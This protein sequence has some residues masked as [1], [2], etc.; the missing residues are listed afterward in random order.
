MKTTLL[1]SLV[2]QMGR[3]TQEK[4]DLVKKIKTNGFSERRCGRVME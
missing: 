1:P 3:H 2:R 4:E